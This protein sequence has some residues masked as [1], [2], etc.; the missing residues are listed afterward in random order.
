L[1]IQTVQRRIAE[2]KI[3]FFIGYNLKVRLFHCS[4]V[5]LLGPIVLQS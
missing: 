5:P 3:V 2:S 4:I 1:D